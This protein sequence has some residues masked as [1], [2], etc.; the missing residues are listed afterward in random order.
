M[1]DRCLPGH[2]QDSFIHVCAAGG[3]GGVALPDEATN[4]SEAIAT[5]AAERLIG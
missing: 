5:R 4:K 2:S 1:E 3:A